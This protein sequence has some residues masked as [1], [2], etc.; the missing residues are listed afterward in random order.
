MADCFLVRRGGADN[1]ASSFPE[2]TYT[3]TYTLIDDGM[4]EDGKTQQFR[5][6]FLTSGVLTF[7]KLGAAKN[8][9]D[10]FA[11]GGGG[12]YVHISGGG[13]GYTKTVKGAIVQE[14]VPYTITIGSGNSSGTGGTTSFGSIVSANGGKCEIR[15]DGSG[16]WG[17]NGGSGGGGYGSAGGQDGNDGTYGGSWYY[18]GTGQHTTTREF[19][20]PNGTLYATG[21][22]GMD[23]S[24]ANP[25]SKAEANSGNGASN[26]RV[27]AQSGIVVIRNARAA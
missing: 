12:G 13:A 6:K 24:G 22:N 19:G 27:S 11:V 7:T 18:A 1:A 10:L 26:G 3:G 5:I 4:A 16:C 20:E 25:S 21:G 14:N 15:Q 23:Y 17:G 9:L 8:G 2:F